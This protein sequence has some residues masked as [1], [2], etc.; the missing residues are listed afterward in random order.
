MVLRARRARWGVTALRSLP[1][2]RRGCR[3]ECLVWAI[4]GREI[5][6][7]DLD[8]MIREDEPGISAGPQRSMAGMLVQAFTDDGAPTHVVTER[9][10]C[11][12]VR[13]GAECWRLSVAPEGVLT[14]LA[15][16]V[17]LR[18][19]DLELEAFNRAFEVTA[20]DRKSRT[21]S[22]MRAWSSFWSSM[23]VDVSWKRSATASW[24][25]GR[26]RPSPTSTLSSRW[27]SPSRRGSRHCEIAASGDAG[28]SAHASVPC[29]TRWRR[30]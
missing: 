10:E 7:F 25:P 4:E 15:D 2:W 18:D 21:T 3:S 29:G 17:S 9:W 22:S 24:W 12:M 16:V 19:Q 14:A 20:D 26:R 27:C 5:R 28:R 23:L 1:S 8:V 13:A 11:A 6:M 30:A